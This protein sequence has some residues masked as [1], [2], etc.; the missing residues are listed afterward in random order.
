[1]RKFFLIKKDL[2][3]GIFLIFDESFFTAIETA[4]IALAP[5]FFFCLVPSRSINRESINF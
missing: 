2:Y 4:K 3:K 5:K 1:M